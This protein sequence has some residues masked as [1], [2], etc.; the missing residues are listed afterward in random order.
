MPGSSAGLT[1]WVS[2][3]CWRP[4][5][6][7]RALKGEDAR[8]AEYYAATPAGK[9]AEYALLYL[10]LIAFLAVMSHDLYRMLGRA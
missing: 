3:R 6:L 7:W 10:G 4:P 2:A 5:Q 1:R 8:P 9:R